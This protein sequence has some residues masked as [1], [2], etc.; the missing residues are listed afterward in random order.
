LIAEKRKSKVEIESTNMT[1]NDIEFKK[2][3]AKDDDVDVD[4][5]EAI[6]KPRVYAPKCPDNA[7]VVLTF[8][9][10]TVTK[11][12][13]SKKKKLLNNISGSMTGGLWAIMGECFRLV[14]FPTILYPNS[15]RLI[16]ETL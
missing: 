5:L 7:P 13:G 15:S 1:T 11:R 6:S 14:S 3:S 12:G 2:V 10:L 9:D 16:H 8:S 4:D